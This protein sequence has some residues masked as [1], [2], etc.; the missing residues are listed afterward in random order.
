MYDGF[1][2]S[3]GAEQLAPLSNSP[4]TQNVS[5][6]SNTFTYRFVSNVTIRQGISER[7]FFFWTTLTSE[8]K[9]LI[10]LTLYIFFSLRC[11]IICLSVYIYAML[12]SCLAFTLVVK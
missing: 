1:V 4:L 8:G 12:C 7:L 10:N 3:R 6:A 2:G 9:Q 11:D 5:P